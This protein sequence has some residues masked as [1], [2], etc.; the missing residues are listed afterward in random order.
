MILER[1]ILIDMM[2]SLSDS[3]FEAAQVYLR[4]AGIDLRDES[5]PLE[6]WC[7]ARAELGIPEA[8]HA[9]AKLFQIGLFGEQNER[10][11]YQW[12]SKAADSSYAP[13]LHMLAEFYGQGFLGNAADLEKSIGLLEKAAGLNYAPAFVT[14]GMMYLTSSAVHQ[15]KDSARVYLERAIALD[16]SVARLVLG[17]LLLETGDAQEI[18]NGLML[19]RESALQANSAAHRILSRFY[20]TGEHGFPVDFSMSDFHFQKAKE[21]EGRKK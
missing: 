8:Q 15:N 7:I 11:A 3:N 9:L 2:E 19:I 20:S 18:K 17:N 13:A 6:E 14:L 4:R 5:F 10:L 1:S 16:S 21:I 12:C